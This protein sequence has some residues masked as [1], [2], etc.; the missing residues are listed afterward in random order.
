MQIKNKMIK[1]F[2][3]IIGISLFCTNIY[4]DEFNITALEISV[5]KKNNTIVG[6]GSVEAIDSQ[7]RIIKA[8]KITYERSKEFLLAE[9]S[10]IINDKIGNILTTNKA[11]YD[12][13]KGQII[14]YEKSELIIDKDYKVISNEILYDT[15]KK[16]I[17][18]NQYSTLEDID[19]NLVNVDMFQF[20]IEN[21]FFKSVGEIKILDINKN[22]YFFKE[23]Y[24]D[25]KKKQMVGS[26]ISVIFDKE[27]FGVGEENDPRLV[28]NDIALSKDESIL[29]KGV[30]TVCKKEG[31]ECPP[32]TIQA[33]KIKHDKARK[34]IY[35]EH[36]VLK[37][38]DFPLFYFPRFFHPDPSVKRQSGFLTPFFTTSTSLGTGFG[39]PYFWAISKDKDLTFTP[40]YY[41][42]E[43]ALFLN[44]YRQA[45]ENGFL[46]LDTGYTQGYKEQTSSK[47]GG[48]RSHIFADLDFD[49]GKDKPFDS[50]LSFKVQQTSNDTFFKVHNINT[51]LVQ[52]DNSNLEN[53]IT[54]NFAQDYTTLDI[55]ASVYE[56]LN[57]KTDKRYEYILPN[58][59]FGKTL[60]TDNFGTIDFSSNALYRNYDAKKETTF[61]TN[62][63][64]WIPKN[65]MTKKGFVNTIE[66]M[67]RNTNYEAK[68][69]AD[70][71]TG[72]TVNELNGVVSFKSTLPMKKEGVGYSNFFSPN[73][74]LRMAPGHMRDLTTESTTLNYAN[75]YSMNRT[76]EIEN[77]ISAVLGLDFITNTKNSKGEESEK[78]S[79]SLGQVFNAEENTDLPSKSSLDQKMSDVVGKINYNFSEIGDINYKFSLDHNFNDLN[80]N[81][82]STNLNFGPVAFNI[83]YLEE[84]SHVGSEHYINNGVTL[85]MNDN[86]KLSFGTK[87]NYKTA[88]TEFYDISYQYMIDC[89]TAGLVYRKEF[90]EDSDSDIAPKETFMFTISFV[91]F[92]GLATPA[93]IK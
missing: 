18:S 12:K 77:G 19:G 69:T 63:L 55:T 56:S 5:D 42:K 21:S 10:V 34:T 88:S 59:I 73:F 74:M 41:N 58:I 4:S 38:Y 60:F 7:G 3:L 6:T 89:L 53:K 91:P 57:V 50:Y 76:S 46:T 43:N 26:D 79:L 92:G 80:Y 86:N 15:E 70:Y 66:G 93:I 45:F 44:E 64:V 33:K 14:S 71:K 51:A 37:V 9:G 48:S 23:L 85:N 25:T 27:N 20:E 83:S 87:K 62:D 81:E 13:M 54:Y 24:L 72:G 40:K 17:S 49:L 32:W 47:T 90:Y 8:D 52:S 22:K 1:I 78:L 30:F 36:A 67:V 2:I 35:Y 68:K 31:D 65:I 28:A 75:L 11:T 84:R 82:I 61:L 39:L 16:I 29:S